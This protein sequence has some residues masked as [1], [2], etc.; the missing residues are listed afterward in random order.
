MK[1]DGVE[2]IF[3]GRRRVF[4]TC[5]ILAVKARKLLSKGCEAYLAHVTEVKSEKLKPK[6][7]PMVQEFLD[8]FPKELS[9]L[10]PNREVEFTIELALGITPIS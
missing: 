2:V 6:D 7:V 4:P 3:K 5:V 10:A 1:L 9:G 8:V